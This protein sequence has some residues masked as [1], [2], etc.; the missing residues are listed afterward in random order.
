MLMNR[1]MCLQVVLNVGQEETEM[2]LGTEAEI[3]E[4]KTIFL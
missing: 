3:A 2:I 4:V 1:A